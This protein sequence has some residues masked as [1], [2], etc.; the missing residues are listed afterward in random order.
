MVDGLLGSRMAFQEHSPVT[1][2]SGLGL[3]LAL[4]GWL[5][6]QRHE[7]PEVPSYSMQHIFIE[8]RGACCE[9]MFA[10]LRVIT[11]VKTVE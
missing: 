9:M 3:T 6:F 1:K 4:Y 10:H 11:G 2:E 5:S 7:F 8:C